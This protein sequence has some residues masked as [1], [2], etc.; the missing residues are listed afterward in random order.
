VPVNEENIPKTAVTTPFDLFE[1]LTMP[2]E[3][4]NATQTFQR[5]MNGILQGL[6]F[7]FCYVD[8][9]LVALHDELEHLRQIFR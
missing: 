9:I 5:F 8:D 7:C 4:R 2:F 1:F 6:E 3:L